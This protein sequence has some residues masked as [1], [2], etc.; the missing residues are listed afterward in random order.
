MANIDKEVEIKTTQRLD[1]IGPFLDNDVDDDLGG[2]SI[3][4]ADIHFTGQR[5]VSEPWFKGIIEEVRVSRS[6]AEQQASSSSD[7]CD[8]DTGTPA[9]D[10]LLQEVYWLGQGKQGGQDAG[11]SFMNC[12]CKVK[13]LIEK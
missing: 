10:D 4:Y 8:F 3:D 7:G 9:L 12:L 2:G 11:I 5:L 13:A 1:L 6:Q